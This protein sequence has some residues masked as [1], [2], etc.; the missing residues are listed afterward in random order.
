MFGPDKQPI[1]ACVIKHSLPGRVRIS[2]RA[3]KYL[4]AYKEEIEERLSNVPEIS[5]ASVTLITGSA[6]IYFD[7]DQVTTE[8]I[9]ETVES[10]VSTYSRI[11]Y[12][13]ERDLLHK[14]TVNERRIQEAP[15]SEMA[16]RIIV[17]TVTLLM[18]WLKKGG[19][20]PAT[21]LLGKFLNMPAL[22]TLSLGMPIFKSGL[23]SL[24]KDMRPNADTLSSLFSP[25]F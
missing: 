10:I 9:C 15:I 25:V 7:S 3:L 4:E 5:S 2:C 21:T 24:R 19:M 11:A 17:T 1:L 12:K 20:K 8:Q 13:S 23:E 16:T 18:A 6:L 22:T 14:T